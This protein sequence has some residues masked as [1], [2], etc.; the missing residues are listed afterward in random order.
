LKLQYQRGGALVEFAIAASALL[1]FFVGAIEAGFM[2][3]SYHSTDYAAR[4]GARWASVRGAKCTNTSGT[5][6]NGN[7]LC[8]AT[9]A[10]VSYFVLSQVPFLNS[11]ATVT[12]QW[13]SPPS[14]WAN[15]PSTCS[16]SNEAPGCIVQVTVKDPIDI[17]I[18]FVYSGT[19]TLQS[20]AQ[21]TISE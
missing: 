18:P 17:Q 20:Q 1:I 14:T 3:Y 13:S 6:A 12:T 21:S 4:I 5:D 9:S 10:A 16:S 11:S 15:A 7:T 19:I 2:Y 8:P